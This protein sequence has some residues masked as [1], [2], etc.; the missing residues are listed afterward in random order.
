MNT[1]TDTLAPYRAAVQVAQQALDNWEIDADSDAVVAG[2][3]DMLS[4]E[5][6]SI[7]VC[8]MQMGAGQVLEECDP[9]GFREGLLNYVDGM[10]K[11]DYEEYGELE[12]ALVDAE[13]ALSEA[14]DALD[15]AD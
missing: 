14:E 12:L 4:D 11:S 2:F 9:I 1:Q 15:K 5:Y 10:D 8:G 3:R 7:D 13:S 6:G